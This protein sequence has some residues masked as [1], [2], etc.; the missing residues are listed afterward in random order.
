MHGANHQ[1]QPK[2]FFRLHRGTRRSC[3]ESYGTESIDRYNVSEFAYVVMIRRI[4]ALTWKVNARFVRKRP[5][6][7]LCDLYHRSCPQP[8]VSLLL[9]F[10]AR[11]FWRAHIVTVFLAL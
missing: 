2:T 6:G 10:L 11:V 9:L 7:G 1:T 3:H 8:R 5:G 4:F